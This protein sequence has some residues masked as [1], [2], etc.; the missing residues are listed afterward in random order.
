MFPPFEETYEKIVRSNTLAE[1]AESI[2]EIRDEYGLAHLVYHAVHLPQSSESNPILLLTY[3]PEWVRRYTTRDYFLIDPVVQQGRRGFLP[4]DWSDV[5]HDSLQAQAFFREAAR[6]EVG[7]NGMTLPVR[8]PGGERALLSITSNV[9][10]RD[11]QRER[12]NIMRDFQLVA[13]VVHDQA[14][15]LS[16]L[17]GPGLPRQLSARERET[18]QLAARGFAPKQIAADLHLS[19]TAV[20]LYLQGARSKLECATLTQG[21]AKAISLDIIQA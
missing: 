19:P 10:S 21:I 4:L 5:D 13:H 15:R 18:L 3:D 2:R 14:V 11:W 7:Q 1:L 6:F 12:L 20:R 9:A 8:G 17:R 16:Q